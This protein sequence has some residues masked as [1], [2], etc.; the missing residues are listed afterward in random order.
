MTFAASSENQTS[1]GFTPINDL[2]AG[3]Y[4]GQF[5]GGLYPG[6]A[7]VAPPAHAAE[8]TTRAATAWDSPQDPKPGVGIGEVLTVL[9]LWGP[10]P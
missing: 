5:Q 7:N 8:G 10:C 4:L 6:G 2:G 3:L 9:G 1:V